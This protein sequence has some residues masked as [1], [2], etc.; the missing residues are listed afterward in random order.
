MRVP[1]RA[2]ACLV[3][4][5]P[6]P[7]PFAGLLGVPVHPNVLW[8]TAEE[9]RSAERGDISLALCE[10][11]GLIWNT[12]FDPDVLAYDG[13]YENSLH[14]SGEFQRYSRELIERLTRTHDLA[15]GRVAEL[16]CGKGEFLA[17][18]CETAGCTG[19]GFDPSYAGEA[20]GRAAGRLSFVRELFGPAS[21]LDGATLVVCRHVL[22]HLE[23]PVGVLALVRRALG[24]SPARLYVEVPSGEYLL[25]EA[26]IWDV[27]YPH[28]TCLTRPALVEIL[29]RSGF[30]PTDYGYS[31]GGQ[32]LWMEASNI[33]A[34]TSATDGD[35]GSATTTAIRFGDRLAAKREG[36]SN[37]L[38]HLLAD[39]S[40]VVWGAGAKGTTFLNAIPTGESVEYVV[41]V[42]PRKHGKYIPGTGQRIV[43]PDTLS[44]RQP[45]TVVVMNPIYAGEI[46]EALREL[47]CS[48]DLVLA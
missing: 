13:T 38:E 2:E 44:G 34:G 12:R 30:H 19:I 28:V 45:G 40:V 14:F 23:D 42:N 39:R 10:G 35:G 9:A 20:E 25:R 47:G 5:R 43:A 37:R 6:A 33:P 46:R 48:A 29:E 11:C 24:E 18:L 16:G 41:D 27:I 7:A 15:G 32:Y 22:E 36:W 3:C 1:L 4:G 8:P 26:A 31:F 17:Q 21:D